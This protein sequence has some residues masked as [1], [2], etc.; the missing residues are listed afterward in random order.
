[1]QNKHGKE[2]QMLLSKTNLSSI[3]YHQRSRQTLFVETNRKQS[4]LTKHE[5]LFYFHASSMDLEDIYK[6]KNARMVRWSSN[7]YSWALEPL[8]IG[9]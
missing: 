1:M 2:M 3:I 9:T 8:C 4:I 6:D 7:N 5:T